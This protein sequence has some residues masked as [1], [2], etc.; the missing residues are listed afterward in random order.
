MR[1]GRGKTLILMVLCMKENGE[2]AQHGIGEFTYPNGNLYDGDYVDGKNCGEG[3][4]T[5]SEGDAYEGDWK[6]NM[7]HG[8]GKY[9][10]GRGGIYDGE[11]PNEMQ[12]GNYHVS[13]MVMLRTLKENEN[14]INGTAESF[15]FVSGGVL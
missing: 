13:M 15:L 10:Y 11:W 14:V 2:N 7:H 9:I 3:K 5:F 6:D 4:F 8:E 12:Q 1:H